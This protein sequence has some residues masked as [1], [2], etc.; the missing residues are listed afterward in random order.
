MSILISELI[1]Y[2][3]ASRPEDDVSVSGGARDA[4][5]TLDVTQMAA[6]D[7]LRAV[8]DNAGDTTQILTITGRNAAGEIVTDPIA[9]NGITPVAGVVTFERYIKSTLSAACAGNVTL[10][11]NTGPNDDLVIIPA[12]MTAASSLFIGAS[13]ESTQTVRYE[14]EFWRNE[15]AESLTLNAAIIQLTTD[16]SASV[17]VGMAAAKDDTVSVANR[18]TAPGGVTFVD[19]AVDINVPG[20][21]LAVNEAIGVWLEL[22]REAGAASIKSSYTTQLE[23][24]SI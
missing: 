23:G 14:K 11:R 18:L 7:V 8:S 10:E 5:C 15:S 19:D 24:T 16:P 2:A 12:G 6:N 20:N 21:S 22:T 1:R 3:A 4:A 17:K 9:L 13:S